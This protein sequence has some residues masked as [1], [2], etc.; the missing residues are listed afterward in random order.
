LLDL[1]TLPQDITYT[2]GDTQAEDLA[3]L[4]PEEGGFQSSFSKL[5]AS[6]KTVH[7]PVKHIVDEKLYASKQL[8]RR[9]REMQAVV[10]HLDLEVVWAMPTRYRYDH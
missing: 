9:C 1:F 4:D 7:D 2:N 3:A 10:R 5:G 6:E 8:A